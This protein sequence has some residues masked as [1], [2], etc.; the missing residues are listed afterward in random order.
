MSTG[1]EGTESVPAG[2]QTRLGIKVRAPGVIHQDR[3]GVQ[4]DMFM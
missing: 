4:E 1:D 2:L 3:V